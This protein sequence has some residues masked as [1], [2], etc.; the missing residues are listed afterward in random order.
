MS[1]SE[2]STDEN[3]AQINQWLDYFA[4]AGIPPQPAAQYAVNFAEQRIPLDRAIISELG[5]D[6]LKELGVD[7]LGDRLSIKNA[8][9]KERKAPKRK[10]IEK[11][12]TEKKKPEDDEISRVISKA[13]ADAK[14]VENVPD[15]RLMTEVSKR[16]NP[17][18]R[19]DS[20]EIIEETVE[21]QV[22]F[23]MN[24]TGSKRRSMDN[25]HGGTERK[26]VRPF[27]SGP[28]WGSEE[29]KTEVQEDQVSSSTTSFAITLGEGKQLTRDDGPKV[30]C[31][32]D[33]I[34]K[35][36][37]SIH[38]RLG[39]NGSTQKQPTQI[40]KTVKNRLGPKSVK[41]RLGL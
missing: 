20:V 21:P 6:E 27:S 16:A 14:L 18:I 1:D 9:K 8:A 26:I 32:F 40:R 24:L 19:E 7:L 22:S 30:R 4:D 39:G 13:K 41:S 28:I 37:K 36:S 33:S 2:S 10:K 23:S 31:S 35:Q 34:K 38:N 3:Y 5:H 29:K 11:I 12:R 25:G 17:F 15:P